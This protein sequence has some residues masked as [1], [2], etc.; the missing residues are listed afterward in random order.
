VL[1]PSI[2]F[3]Q[4]QS[5]IEKGLPFAVYRK[6]NS[7]EVVAYLQSDLSNQNDGTLSQG[8]LI[9]P[10]QF[11]QPQ[12]VIRKDQVLRTSWNSNP[13]DSSF[14]ESK[15]EDIQRKEKGHIDLVKKALETIN[16]SELKKVVLATS[17]MSAVHLTSPLLL[18]KRILDRYRNTFNFWFFH[19]VCGN[20][21][22]ATPEL[23]LSMDSNRLHTMA[24][25]GT[26]KK[27]GAD[28]G[29]KEIE[30][31]ALV[32][33]EIKQTISRL[34]SGN[35]NIII[36]NSQN[37]KAGAV[38]H[39]LTHISA[40]VNATP[41]EVAKALHPTPAVGGVPKSAAIHFIE[42]QENLHRSYYAG[43]LGPFEAHQADWYVNLRSMRIES[44]Q[45]EVFVGGGITAD[46][47]PQSEWEELIQKA[48]TMGC[49]LSK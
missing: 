8:F 5:H 16:K 1:K 18:F 13:T 35:S 45:A 17:L 21:L 49:I 4:I 41:I 7:D 22:G 38:E 36:E 29:H 10:F 37:K 46:S 6:P 32:V 12:V 31:Q 11:D 26:R 34:T 20:W 47:D 43:F 25:A 42:S 39:I 44:Q 3:E 19:P 40:E 30:E 33:S 28:W 9:A 15:W 24:L 27:G 48:N 2:F 14:V 23:L